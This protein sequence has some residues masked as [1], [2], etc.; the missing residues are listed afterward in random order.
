MKDKLDELT[1]AQISANDA[2]V[3]LNLS[4]R[5]FTDAIEY[6]NRVSKEFGEMLNRLDIPYIDALEA[7]DNG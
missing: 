1:K 2:L 7:E 4:I 5:S 6:L 3:A